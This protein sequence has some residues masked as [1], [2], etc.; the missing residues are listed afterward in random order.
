MTCL[1]D[2]IV[3]AAGQ[4][5][6]AV[7]IARGDLALEIGFARLVE[8]QEEIMWWAEAAQILVIWA[9]KVLERSLETGR[10]F[11]GEWLCLLAGGGM[12]K[13][14]LSTCK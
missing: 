4:Q 12:Y 9:T 3:R 2:I 1:P 11:C 10:S 8:M 14:V 5:P 13:T 6:T 7:M